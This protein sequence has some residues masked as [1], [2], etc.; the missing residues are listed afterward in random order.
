MGEGDWIIVDQKC[1]KGSG[2]NM[3][4][5][6][7]PGLRGSAVSKQYREAVRGSR[8]LHNTVV[9]TDLSSLGATPGGQ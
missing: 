1:A 5:L 2:T 3:S 4:R 8:A 9:R 6:G 7:L